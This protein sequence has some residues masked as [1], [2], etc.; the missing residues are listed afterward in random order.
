MRK[1]YLLIAGA[2]LSLPLLAQTEPTFDPQ[3]DPKVI[4]EQTFESDWDA[5]SSTPVDT[6]NGVDYFLNGKY[7]PGSNIKIWEN[8]DYQTGFIH[9][10]T[11]INLFNGVMLSD[12]K[13]DFEGGDITKPETFKSKDIYTIVSD[14]AGDITRQS[15][16]DQYGTDGGSK[17]FRFTAGD[18]SSV[19]N[20]ASGSVPEYRRNL[21]IRLTP[22]AIE[23]NSSYRITM[24][25]KT[26]KRLSES[27]VPNATA[28]NFRAELM[29][30]YFSSEK[31]FSMGQD[32]SSS[33]TFYYS[34]DDFVEGEWTKITY[35]S[36]YLN[37]TVAERFCYYNQ[38]HDTW[39]D[40]WKW[41]GPEVTAAGFDSLHII[42][43]PNKY[44]LRVSFRGDSTVYDLDNISITKSTIGGIQHTGNMLRVDFG[45]QTNL[46]DQAKAAK[47]RTNIAA[48]EVPGKFFTVWGK[49]ST[50]H[51]WRK[52]EINTAE[53]HDD[54]YMYMWSKPRVLPNGQ[55]RVQNFDGFDEVRVDFTNPSGE[56]YDTLALKYNGTLYPNALDEEWVAAGKRVFDFKNELSTPNP[57]ISKGVYPLKQYPPVLRPNGAPYEDGSFGLDPNLSSIKLILSRKIEF[58]ADET[59]G[60]GNKAFCQVFKNGTMVE[61]WPVQESTETYTIFKRQNT[62]TP[63]SG[64]YTFKFIQIKGV[65]DANYS[66]NIIL[67]YHFGSFDTNPS[68]RLIAQ[69]DW[70]NRIN[71]KAAVASRPIPAD[72]W[73]H[74]GESADKFKEGNGASQGTKIGLYPLKKD[75]LLVGGEWVYDDVLFYISSRKNTTTGNVY[76]IQHLPAGNFTLSFR[77]AGRSSVNYPLSVLFYAKPEQALEAGNDKGFA[78]LE[79]IANK[80]LLLSEEKPAENTDIGEGGTSATWKDGT[81]LMALNFTV[82]AEGD[83]IFEFMTAGS[84]N[85]MG[86]AISNYWIT[87]SGNLSFTPV[88]NFNAAVKSVTEKLAS[89]TEN[90]YKG[91]DYRALQAAETTGKGF[92]QALIDANKGHQ[93]SVYA[94]QIKSMEDAI[95]TLQLHMDTVDLFYTAYDTVAKAVTAQATYQNL[96]AYTKLNA[97][98]TQYSTYDCSQYTNK[99]ISDAADILNA[100]VKNLN[101]R[102]TKNDGF[103]E[104]LDTTKKIIDAKFVIFENPEL[105]GNTLF[106][107]DTLNQAYEAAFAVKERIGGMVDSVFYALYDGLEGLRIDYLNAIDAVKARTRQIRELYVL[108]VDT[109]GYDFG[110]TKDSIQDLVYGL[111][112]RDAELEKVLRQAAVLQIYKKFAAGEVFDTLDVSA[113]VP[114][115]FMAS[116]GEIGVNMRKKSSGTMVVSSSDNT[117]IFPGWNLVFGGSSAICYPGKAAMTDER[118]VHPFIGGLH[119]EPNT[120]GT[121]TVTATD[122]PIAEY[123]ATITLGQNNL[124]N[125]YVK[126]ATDSASV[127]VKGTKLTGSKTYGFENVKIALNKKQEVSNLT[128]SY[129]IS[130]A[131]GSGHVDVTGVNLYLTKADPKYNYSELAAAQETK[132]AEM[133]T[134]VAPVAFA[135]DAV[136]VQYF[137]LNGVQIAAPEAGKIVIKRTI[138]SNGVSIVEKILVK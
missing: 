32:V 78:L 126:V 83:Y 53:Y 128:Y 21:F 15:A 40:Y 18:G 90:K 94:A 34:K 48:V 46:K 71:D 89:V 67:N 104:L 112:V 68:I 105:L 20:A 116:E 84:N 137:N 42:R 109:L 99:E 2:V 61:I 27:N 123:Y 88:V 98:K 50:T 114:N 106:E 58:D 118:E 10:D 5:W 91:A 115:Y 86:V 73:I 26:T 60:S 35:M 36:Y 122:M 56:E 3:T 76:C 1:F 117:S 57:N 132:L 64:D 74:T 96:D 113:L 41:K 134:F 16:L 31:N 11:V 47:E 107:H 28:P 30:G 101:E 54:G 129:R 7:N 75:S 38:Y 124:S 135:A 43:Q 44:F 45:Y 87:P 100:G 119:F 13:D 24:Y 14:A 59:V 17:Y 77:L 133:I 52:V 130:S 66:D 29:R 136:A 69:S 63:L 110:A 125:G 127:E 120:T 25:M 82:P 70:R 97:L 131:S 51:A 121:V 49:D 37:N 79:G 102:I 92:I 93:P 62:S 108:A 33:N 9:R 72:V 23:E 111:R 55:Q 85:Y 81:K 22:G 39:C 6:I 12:N 65:G 103:A 4:Y 8:K 138:L 80:Q 19:K 95:T